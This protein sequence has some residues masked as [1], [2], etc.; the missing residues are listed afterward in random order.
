MIRCRSVVFSLSPSPL[1]LA[2][3]PLAPVAHGQAS[4]PGLV[5]PVPPASSVTVIVDSFPSADGR[6]R[7]FSITRSTTSNGRVPVVIFANSGGTFVRN[8]RSYQEWARL[9][10]T[11]GFAGILYDAPDV[12]F[13]QP[14]EDRTRLGV[15]TLDSVLRVLQRGQ[16]SY[17]VDVTQVIVWAGSSQTQVGTPFALQGERPVAGYVLYYG[18]G[19]ASEPRADVPVLMVR[20]GQD[21]PSL[22][23]SLDSLAVRLTQA[24]A[25]LTIVH[26]PAGAHAF[27]IIDSTTVTAAVI[28]QTLDFMSRAIDPRYRASIVA[29]APM[30]RAAA[31]F[32]GG[33]WADAA[34]LYGEVAAQRPNDRIVVWRLGVA[35][36]ANAQPAEALASFDRARA[37]GQ[38]GARDIGLPATR[39]ALRAQRKHARWN[40][41]TGRSHRIPPSAPKSKSTP[42]WRRCSPI[43]A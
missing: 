26:H 4:Q 14:A 9:V 28:A 19:I 31:A 21:S 38:G 17:A 24:G 32:A 10:T 3:A 1:S 37:L 34:R 15:A 7:A 5:V 23:A 25:P 39:A 41:S 20:A 16:A 27:D 33:R 2:S 13:S 22:N 43:R 12:D 42:N 40:G 11:R 18:S 8:A 6:R 36:L 29:G 30:A 35:Q